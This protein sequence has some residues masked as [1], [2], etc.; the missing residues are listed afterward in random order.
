MAGLGHGAGGN[1]LRA[2]MRSA[3]ILQFS[4]E[5]APCRAPGSPGARHGASSWENCKMGALRISALRLF[6]PA[7]WPSPAIAIGHRSAVVSVGRSDD[8]LARKHSTSSDVP[9]NG[10]RG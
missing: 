4:Q 5:D 9:P 1:N 2:E 8:V 6:P 10:D 3:P 7:P